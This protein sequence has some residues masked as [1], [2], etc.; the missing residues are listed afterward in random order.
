MIYQATISFSDGRTDEISLNVCAK[1]FIQCTVIFTRNC[2]SLNT[3]TYLRIHI[4]WITR[5]LCTIWANFWRLIVAI[6]QIFF[7]T[8]FYSQCLYRGWAKVNTNPTQLS[9]LR[10]RGNRCQGTCTLRCGC[11]VDW[12]YVACRCFTFWNKPFFPSQLFC[13]CEDIFNKIFN[14]LI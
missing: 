11:P 10:G 1:I 2:C 4:Y 9:V 13:I 14:Y 7:D 5:C 6:C 12:R 3:L 8:E